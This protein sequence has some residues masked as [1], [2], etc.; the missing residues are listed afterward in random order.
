MLYCREVGH[1]VG[2]EDGQGRSTQGRHGASAEDVPV[3]DRV[4]DISESAVE[5]VD[6]S[7]RRRRGW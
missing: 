1:G 5:T 3:L 2:A 7:G 6:I 4:P